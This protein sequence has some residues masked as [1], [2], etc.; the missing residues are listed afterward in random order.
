MGWGSSQTTASIRTTRMLAP[1]TRASQSVW[2]QGL[3][4]CICNK[5]LGDAD[6]AVQ[7]L[8]F[9]NHWAAGPVQLSGLS[10]HR[11]RV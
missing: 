3:R 10:E 9:K 4:I 11:P 8:Y 6:A 7:D 2:G 1:N 5:F